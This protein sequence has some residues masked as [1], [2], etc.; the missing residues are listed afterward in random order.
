MTDPELLLDIIY[1]STFKKPRN[2]A[3]RAKLVQARRIV[4]S[5]AM[6]AY[7]I[8]LRLQTIL[9]HGGR[10]SFR[11]SHGRLD[12]CRY[13]ARLPHRVTWVEYALHAALRRECQRRES[14]RGIAVDWQECEDT[15][16]RGSRIGWLMYQHDKI[17]TAFAA[18]YFL[19]VNGAVDGVH[20]MGMMQ[21]PAEVLWCTDDTPLPWTDLITTDSEGGRLV[22]PIA[23]FLTDVPHYDR[24]NVGMRNIPG[25]LRSEQSA[26]RWSDIDRVK[27]SLA[28]RASMM[29]AFLATFNKV[30]IFGEQ[31]I[32]RSHGFVAAGGYHRF[33]DHKVL[34]INIPEKAARRVV[35]QAMAPTAR[36]WPW[37]RAS[38]PWKRSTPWS[39]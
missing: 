22:E 3:L 17:E 28:G 39:G 26:M 36:R 33:L 21:V 5:D 9:P 30:P 13:F 8:D 18:Q 35:R 27:Q 23:A 15:K 6:A 25:L 4:L 11:Q 20:K 14:D 34:T 16:K 7:L 2:P 38:S 12:D 31:E 1:R 37:R 32:V 29:W 19:G 24:P 10:T